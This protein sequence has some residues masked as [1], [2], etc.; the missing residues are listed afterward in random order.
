MIDVSRPPE[1]CDRR[2]HVWSEV[3]HPGISCNLNLGRLIEE[4]KYELVPSTCLPVTF[5]VTVLDSSHIVSA[6]KWSVAPFTVLSEA[7][8]NYTS[9]IWLD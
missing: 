3:K 8:G 9:S 4:N 7:E 2:T 5:V 1:D 6:Q